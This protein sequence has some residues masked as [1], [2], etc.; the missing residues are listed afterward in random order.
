[1]AADVSEC[2]AIETKPNLKKPET[3]PEK[4]FVN[5]ITHTKINLKKNI[6]MYIYIFIHSFIHMRQNEFC[7]DSKQ[8]TPIAPTN[9]VLL[10]ARFLKTLSRTISR[11]IKS[12]KCLWY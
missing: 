7:S 8:N 4:A 1:M 11:L 10:G 3:K 5:L 6:Y 12:L 9:H 2:F